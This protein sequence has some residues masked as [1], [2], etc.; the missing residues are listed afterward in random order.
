MNNK[1]ASLDLGECVEKNILP[2]YQQ[3]DKA[4]ST[5]HV[6]RVVRRSLELARATG[7]DIDMAYV[8]AAYH[9]MGMSGP[10][11]VHHL[12]SG[13]I[14]AS[15]ARLKR[16]FTADQIKIM[17]EAVEDHRASAAH[18]PRSIYGRIV[19]EADRDLDPDIVFTRAIQ[20]GLDNYPQLD[21]EG[22]W[23]RFVQHMEEKYS[24]NGYIKLWIPQSDNASKLKAVREVIADKAEL[25]RVFDRIMAG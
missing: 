11:A 12:T 10:R 20:F 4:H 14:L 25:R 9:D 15:D 23:K 13:R 8:I 24:V 6:M 21:R 18:A 22:Q 19:A 16:W 5:A 17:R 1:T 7:A 2:G 3:F